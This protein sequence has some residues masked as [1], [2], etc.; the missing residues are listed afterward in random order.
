MTRDTKKLASELRNAKDEDNLFYK[1]VEYEKGYIKE[2]EDAEKSADPDAIKSAIE[3]LIAFY[4]EALGVA[5]SRVTRRRIIACIRS[6][7]ADAFRWGIVIPIVSFPLP[8]HPI[9]PPAVEHIQDAVDPTNLG[10]WTELPLQIITTVQNSM[11]YFRI[12]YGE[13]VFSDEKTLADI[14]GEIKEAINSSTTKDDC[15]NNLSNVVNTHSTLNPLKLFLKHQKNWED[16]IR[17]IFERH[18][19]MELESLLRQTRTC[20]PHYEITISALDLA[21]AAMLAGFIEK[22]FLSVVASKVSSLLSEKKIR[23]EFDN[24]KV[25]LFKDKEK[26]PEECKNE[27]F[28]IMKKYLRD[29]SEI[30]AR[31]D[32]GVSDECKKWI[33]KIATELKEQGRLSQDAIKILRKPLDINL[34]DI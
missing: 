27:F 28:Y 17:E 33:K 2:I 24:S 16:E 9:R 34:K 30:R 6:L 1:V 10:A 32:I 21:V 25:N 18:I 5:T 19:S 8:V 22:R 14:Y 11:A 7:K 15:I 20:V 12:E 13:Y 26:S 29:I 31:G 3:G 23:E 4:K